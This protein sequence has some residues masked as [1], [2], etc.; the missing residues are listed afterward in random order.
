MM[1]LLALGAVAAFAQKPQH[2]GNERS[3]EARMHKLDSIVGLT[4]D[5]KVEIEK[6]NT[7]FKT[8]HQSLREADEKPDRE[9]MKTIRMEHK[10][11]LESVLTEEQKIKLAA[12]KTV[13]KENH[14]AA[15]EEIKAYKESN[16]KPVLEAHRLDM[17]S[18]LSPEELQTLSNARTKIKAIKGGEKKEKGQ[19]LT[20][21]QRT[22]VKAII[23]SDVQPIALAHKEK[24]DEIKTKLKPL[25]M[26]WMA[27]VEQIA[28]KHG[29]ESKRGH[30]HKGHAN[31]C[32]SCSGKKDGKKGKGD[33]KKG[34]MRDGDQ[35]MNRFLLSIPGKT[36]D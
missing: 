21:E 19:R 6:I 24:L 14:K 33:K 32:E 3:T 20:E 8:K 23:T 31:G 18:E 1:A 26:T 11:R 13:E 34:K 36:E 22:Q 15:R 12:S 4:D 7:E 16:I 2:H 5:Q 35:M 30:G 28:E 29:V 10:A 17:K 27:D 9:A 25:K